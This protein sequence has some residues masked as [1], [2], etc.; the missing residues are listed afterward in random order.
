MC[1]TINMATATPTNTGAIGFQFEGL[2]E[3]S[4]LHLFPSL[5]EAGYKPV[6]LSEQDIRDVFNEQS[7]N[8]VDHL[9]ELRDPSGEYIYFFLQ[10][11]WKL[12]TNQREVSQF[13]DCCSRILSRIPVNKRGT[14]YRI[15]VTRSQPSQNGEKSLEEGGAYIIQSMTSQSILA[16]ITGQF[17][18]E[19]LG[20]RSLA[21]KMIQSMPSLL[22][23]SEPLKDAPEILDSS[24]SAPMPKLTYKTQVLVNK[25]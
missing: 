8:G 20:N 11:K 22:P 5:Q 10:E 19:I 25:S 21:T 9:L 15:W 12:M 14:V 4:L 18:C 3:R 13:L 2:V 7:L 6:L 1:L 17:I 16:Q 24:K 23:E